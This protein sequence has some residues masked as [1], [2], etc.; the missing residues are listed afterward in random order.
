MKIQEI[1]YFLM[2]RLD[3]TEPILHNNHNNTN[4]V[5]VYYN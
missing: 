4:I 5:F 1:Y 3:T 2:N